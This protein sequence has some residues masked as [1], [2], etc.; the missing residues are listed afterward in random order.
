MSAGLERLN[1]VSPAEAEAEL[2]KCCGS[3]NWARAMAQLRPFRDAGA[4]AD[5][6]DRIWRQLGREDWLAAFRCHPRIGEKPAQGG[7]AETRRWAKQEQSGAQSAKGDIRAALAEGNRA[8]EVRFGHIYIVCA[9]GRTSEEMLALLGQRL[10][11]DPET[12]LR[13]AA[14]EQ[15]KITQLRLEKLLR[16]LEARVER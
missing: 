3:K 7:S 16:E 15:R 9:T 5:A 6:A 12:E 1:Q 11:N 8:Y 4:L 13:I 10:Q 2:L 14:E